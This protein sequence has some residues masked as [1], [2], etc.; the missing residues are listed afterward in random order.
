MQTAKPRLEWCDRCA[1]P[2][3]MLTVDE[4]SGL[5]RHN[6][7]EIRERL[8]TGKVHFRPNPPTGVLI[9]VNTL[10]LIR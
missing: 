5:T 8:A 1:S 2:S 7:Q 3:V 10:W 9:C 6:A 4:A